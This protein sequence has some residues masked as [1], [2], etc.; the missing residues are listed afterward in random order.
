[1]RKN[2]AC[3]CAG[4]LVGACALPKVDI[5]P[6]LGPAASGGT[7]GSNSQGGTGGKGAAPGTG[8]TGATSASG[9][10]D[11]TGQGG[12]TDDPREL[13]CGDYCNT[14][15]QNCLKSPA[16]DYSGI[17]DCLNTCFT[18]D[19]PLGTDPAQPNSVQCRDVH[20]HLAATSPNPHCFHSARVPTGTSCAL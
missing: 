3:F 10:T 14:Y 11:T 8:G 1:M 17:D 15:L 12:N 19:W 7:G 4:A 16:N 5:D 2:V 13:A 18:S 6:S 20:A 9:G